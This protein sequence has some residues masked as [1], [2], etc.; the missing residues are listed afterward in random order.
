[1]ANLQ[2][3]GGGNACGRNLEIVGPKNRAA[4]QPLFPELTLAALPGPTPTV[5]TQVLPG[6]P[7]NPTNSQEITNFLGEPGRTWD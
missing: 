6:N 1:V 5:C 7:G 4:L 2:A 3:K